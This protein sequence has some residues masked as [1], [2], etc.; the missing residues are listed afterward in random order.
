MMGI[1]HEKR[2]H[3]KKHE[4]YFAERLSAGPGPGFWVAQTIALKHL[5][6]WFRD[7]KAS[8]EFPVRSGG[9]GEV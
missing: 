5:I 6:G 1:T 9:T 8:Q 2:Y 4:L 3:Q 7:L